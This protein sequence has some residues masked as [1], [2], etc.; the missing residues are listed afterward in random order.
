M[1][2]FVILLIVAILLLIR[3]E[4]EKFA[5]YDFKC[6]LLAMKINHR[7]VNNSFGHSIKD[8]T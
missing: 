6:F 7:G 1:I 4:R 8:S 5:N 2:V 3:T